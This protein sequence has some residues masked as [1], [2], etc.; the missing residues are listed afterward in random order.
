VSQ[1]DRVLLWNNYAVPHFT[2]TKT[3]TARWDRFAQ[4][5]PLPRYAEPDFPT[6]WWW[7]S[8]R[9]TKAGNPR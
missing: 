1:G 2:I 3:R 6:V 9:A 5:D 8:E 4:P 7:D